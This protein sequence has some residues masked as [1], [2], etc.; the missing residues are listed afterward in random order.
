MAPAAFSRRRPRFLPSQN[1]SWLATGQEPRTVP[2][3]TSITR[4]LSCQ[5]KFL[6]S[7]SAQYD[8]RRLNAEPSERQRIPSSAPC[9]LRSVCRSPD[10]ET[11]IM[12][13]AVSTV[14]RTLG[15]I[16][17]VDGGGCASLQ[18]LSVCY[19]RLRHPKTQPDLSAPLGPWGGPE[20]LLMGPQST[21]WGAQAAAA[22][23]PHREHHSTTSANQP[24]SKELRATPPLH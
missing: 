10:S 1:A 5:Q 8:L 12:W 6:E 17:R 3:F 23:I 19:A 24:G 2:N 9:I 16:R 15:R 20:W 18:W 7:S 11:Q 13:L 22:A 14:P 21:H 4:T